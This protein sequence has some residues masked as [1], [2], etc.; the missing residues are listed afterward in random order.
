[1][2]NFKAEFQLTLLGVAVTDFVN[3]V[4]SKASIKNFFSLKK[5]VNSEK[6]NPT[7]SQ[8]SAASGNS[9]S[10][11]GSSQSNYLKR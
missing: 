2:V 11:P 4:E 8:P 1:M 7:D 5:T 9:S 3:E 10:R 6:S